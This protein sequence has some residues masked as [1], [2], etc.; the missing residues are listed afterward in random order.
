MAALKRRRTMAIKENLGHA[1]LDREQKAA[2]T[3]QPTDCLIVARQSQYTVYTHTHSA[4]PTAQCLLCQDKPVE[5][6][7]SF[8][9]LYYRHVYI[10]YAYI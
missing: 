8:T 10:L 4:G 6:A 2:N 7:S 3:V 5:C 9:L 1:P